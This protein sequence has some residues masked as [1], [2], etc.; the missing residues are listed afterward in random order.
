MLVLSD[1]FYKFLWC[2]P[3]KNKYS[4]T[5][6]NE[7]SNT[8]TTSKQKPIKKESDRGTEFYNSTFQFF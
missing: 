5:I 4:Q 2:I 7:F 3:L 8:L 1:S 6:T